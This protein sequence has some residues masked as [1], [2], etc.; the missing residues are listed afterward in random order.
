MRPSSAGVGKGRRF[1]AHTVH[2]TNIPRLHIILN[3]YLVYS[4]SYMDGNSAWGNKAKEIFATQCRRFTAAMRS[5]RLHTGCLQ[6]R[7]LYEG[8][9]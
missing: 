9:V 3:Y 8:H 5:A 7:E 1:S 4:Q 6:V 2:P